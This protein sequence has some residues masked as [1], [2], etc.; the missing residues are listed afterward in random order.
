MEDKDS[1]RL[2]D[3]LT[4]AISQLNTIQLLLIEIQMELDRL[5]L[6]KP[7]LPPQN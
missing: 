7:V 6:I 2:G 1:R 3:A 5:R 4:Q